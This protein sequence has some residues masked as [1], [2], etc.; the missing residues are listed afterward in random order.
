MS[1]GK[2]LQFRVRNADS[3][4][5]P[6]PNSLFGLGEIV[7]PQAKLGTKG[8]GIG[9]KEFLQLNPGGGGSRESALFPSQHLQVGLL[10]TLGGLSCDKVFAASEIRLDEK[11]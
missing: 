8:Q 9:G 2:H 5:Y 1:Q 4:C 11:I 6:P 10:T 3:E 7:A